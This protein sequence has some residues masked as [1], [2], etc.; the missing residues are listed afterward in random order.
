ME[1]FSFLG[2]YFR[3]IVSTDIK[4]NWKEFIGYCISELFD[5]GVDSKSTEENLELRV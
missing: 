2:I 4:Y 5:K 1:K 3:D